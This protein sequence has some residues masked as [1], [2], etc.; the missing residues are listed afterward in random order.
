MTPDTCK[1]RNCQHYAEAKDGTD[2]CVLGKD[3]PATDN[4]PLWRGIPVFNMTDRACRT[5]RSLDEAK[6]EGKE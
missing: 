2:V 1:K 6:K 4:K 3:K 5:L